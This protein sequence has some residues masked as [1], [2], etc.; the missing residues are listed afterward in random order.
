MHT[1]GKKLQVTVLPLPKAWPCS[2]REQNNK[3][4]LCKDILWNMY[5]LISLHNKH[6]KQNIW[7]TQHWNNNLIKVS[8]LES[9]LFIQGQT[10]YHYFCRLIK[11]ERESFEIRVRIPNCKHVG[12]HGFVFF[13]VACNWENMTVALAVL[14][15]YSAITADTAQ[16][17][18][19][20]PTKTHCDG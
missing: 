16:P 11:Q 1:K 2:K 5:D 7:K 17:W 4:G 15:G 18:H 12:L 13:S 14:P 8:R 9:T 10:Q 20:S 19:S 6:Y 3:N